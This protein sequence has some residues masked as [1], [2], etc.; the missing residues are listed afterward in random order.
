MHA[1]GEILIGIKR[2]REGEHHRRR[3]AQLDFRGIKQR[4]RLAFAFFRQRRQLGA[5]ELCPA[6]VCRGRGGRCDSLRF[7]AVITGGQR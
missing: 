6:F 1:A 3:A 4:Q 2:H 7:T 5:I